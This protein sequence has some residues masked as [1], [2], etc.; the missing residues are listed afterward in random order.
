[1]VLL[2]SI[3][4]RALIWSATA[5]RLKSSLDRARWSAFGFSIAGA[6][7]ASIASQLSGDGTL[8]IWTTAFG[9]ICLASSTFF[10]ARLL[11]SD[12]V[13]GWVRARGASEALRREAFKFA[14]KA[15]PYDD[16]KIIENEKRLDEVRAQ[17]ESHLDDLLPFVVTRVAAQIVPVEM[18]T[19][20]QYLHLRLRLQIEEYFK[21]KAAQYQRHARMLYKVEFCLAFA[22]TLITAV[23]TVTGKHVPIWGI[24]FDLASL[25]AV[26]T[27]VSG[28]ILA[29]IEATKL[30]YLSVTY[31][32]TAR[33]LE[34][35][36]NK[37]SRMGWSDFVNAC[38]NILATE[39][40]S[41]VAKWSK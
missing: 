25:T 30:G 38:E 15:L 31:L 5:D 35:Q 21:P 12:R 28:A 27:T 23:A 22:A 33:R 19:E 11:G 7:A 24:T 26:L 36:I 13:I 16:S 17:I 3:S 9:M 20:D 1:M 34:D 14:A 41:W 37:R 18:L 10:V 2:Q 39:N 4:E 6:L 29:H 8:R 40:A 32:A